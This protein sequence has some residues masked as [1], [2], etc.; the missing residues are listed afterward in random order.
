VY[1]LVYHQADFHDV[2]DKPTIKNLS[3]D[4]K[5]VDNIIRAADKMIHDDGD[6]RTAQKALKLLSDNVEKL[7]KASEKKQ[8]ADFTFSYEEEADPEIF[9]V[10]YIWEV[11]VCVVTASSIDWDTN[12]IQVFALIEDDEDG[13]DEEGMTENNGNHTGTEGFAKD[14]SDI[15]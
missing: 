11:I 10:P 12:R 4:L 6:A 7:Q 8:E 1:A 13:A 9:F 15:V 2:V 14:V 5:L 3:S